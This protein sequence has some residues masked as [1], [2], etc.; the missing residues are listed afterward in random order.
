MAGFD[1]THLASSTLDRRPK[2][3]RF[4]AGR[5]RGSLL[6]QVVQPRDTGGRL[7]HTRRVTVR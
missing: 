3:G 4:H 7:E 6:I 1:R 5:V 2:D